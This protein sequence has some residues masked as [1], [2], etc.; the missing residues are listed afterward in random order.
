MNWLQA[1]MHNAM[2]LCKAEGIINGLLKNGMT[3]CMKNPDGTQIALKQ[4]VKFF[5]MELINNEETTE[6]SED[7]NTN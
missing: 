5:S 4:G 1:M 3:I 6:E 2:L 7:E